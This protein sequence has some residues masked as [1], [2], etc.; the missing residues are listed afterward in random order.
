MRAGQ[1]RH[2]IDWLEST[3]TQSSVGEPVTTWSTYTAGVW[4]NVKQITDQLRGGETYG[5]Q[6]PQTRSKV[7]I[8]VNTRYAAGINTKMAVRYNSQNYQIVDVNNVEER[9]REL[10][11][12]AVLVS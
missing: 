8:E 3:Y 4:A 9:N 6:I 2:Q 7:M 5:G 10:V 11:V 12:L 1:L